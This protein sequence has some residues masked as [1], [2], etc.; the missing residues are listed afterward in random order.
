M[1]YKMLS[2]IA[3]IQSGLVLNRKEASPDSKISILYRQLNLRSINE[4]GTI[5]TELLSDFCAAATLHKQFITQADDIVMRLFAPHHPVLITHAFTGLV[6]PSQFSIIRITSVAFRPAFLSHY[7]SLYDVIDEVAAKDGGLATRG[8]KIST[9]S[10]IQIPLLPLNQQDGIVAYMD[11]HTQRKR[12]SL[13]LMEQYDIQ[14][15]SVIKRAIG[16]NMQ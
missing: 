12:L 4:D 5:D 14:A 10:R 2:E 11:A 9:L 16:G 8:I 6:V 7:L 3:E 13:Q 15:K 1:T